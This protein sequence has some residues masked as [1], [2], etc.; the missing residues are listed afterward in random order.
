M[1]FQ[2]PIWLWLLVLVPLLA[3]QYLRTRSR[4]NASARVL[5][6]NLHLLSQAA[7]PSS[8]VKRHLGAGLYLL[9]LTLGFITLARPQALLPQPDNLAGVMLSIDIS[10]SMRA[11][12]IEPDRMTAAK[13]AAQTFV[14]ALPDE[15]KV[16]LVSFAG[17][18]TLEVPLGTEHQ[19]IIDQIEALEMARRTAIGEG[20]Q[21]SLKAFPVDAQGRPLGP[22]TVVLLS[23]GRNNSGI[24]PLEVVKQAKTMGVVVHTIGLGKRLT[25][26]QTQ[27]NN[28]MAFDEETLQAIAES[29]GGQY[30]AAE[31]AEALNSAYRKLGRV[32][33][34]KAAHTEVSGLTGLLAGLMLAS[35]LVLS[36][37]G[38]RVI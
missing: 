21:E 5:H 24:E 33:G 15:A 20:L 18:A 35:S 25:D 28:F 37:L 4:G 32:V 13:K 38:R 14:R 36:G 8:G 7:G 6:P 11:T 30:Y 31:S 2:Y 22:S 23:D 10:R 26:E 16:G 1:G 12:D 9:A 3:W 34:W 29:T 17:Y 27:F 19:R